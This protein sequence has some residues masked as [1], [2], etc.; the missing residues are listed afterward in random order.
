MTI[1]NQIKDEKLQYDIKTEAAKIS[2]LSS[3]KFHKYEYLTGE[4][5]LPSTQQ[6]I[7]QQSKIYLF[8]FGKSF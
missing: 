8:F 5:I 1:N 4:D 7:I 2:A 6:Q 3:G